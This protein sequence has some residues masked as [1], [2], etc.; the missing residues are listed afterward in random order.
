LAAETNRLHTETMFN[1]DNLFLLFIFLILIA[2]TGIQLFYYLRYYLPVALFE[3]TETSTEKPPVSIIICARNEAENLDSFL[4]MVLT[5]DYPDYEVIVVNDCSADNTYNVLG[6]Y[7]VE[8]PHLKVSSINKDPKFTHNKKLA[9]LIGI[10]AARNELLLFTDAD[11]KPESNMWLA[12]VASRFTDKTVFVLGYGGYLCGKGLLNAYIRYDC[13]TIAMQYLGMAIKG[14]PYMG[15]G[16]NLAY[17]RSAFFENK[18]YGVH[19]QLVSG[20]DDLFVN[21]NAT[22]GNTAVEFRPCAHT[23][24]VPAVTLSD[25]FK[26]KRRHL[27]TARYYKQND[28]AMLL[29]EP[30]SRT[31]FYASLAV[32][33]INGFMWPY[34]LACF[35]LRLCIQS[36]VLILVCKKLNEH[37]IVAASLFFD[38][39]S[40]LINLIFY[41]FKYSRRTG[42]MKWK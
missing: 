35:G 31:V 41:T 16:R 19:Y 9:Q 21:G 10:K 38:I 23:R 36:T 18:G 24:S 6:K 4:P 30:A 7:L 25:F 22:A 15:V 2:A 13:I 20:D 14:Q 33:L 29:A 26:Q 39:I 1:I 12:T 8:Y 3:P 5:Q 40:P 11:C 28:R 17:R 34:A 37:K 42:A 32:L 27:T